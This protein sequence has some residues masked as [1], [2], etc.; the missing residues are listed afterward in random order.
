MK[1]GHWCLVEISRG[2]KT[3]HDI[4]PVEQHLKALT[5]VKKIL[6]DLVTMDCKDFAQRYGH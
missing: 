1:A 2:K 5:E 4:L 3:I 6:R